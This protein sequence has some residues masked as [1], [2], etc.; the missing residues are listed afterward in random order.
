MYIL[1]EESE[2]GLVPILDYEI[3]CEGLEPMKVFSLSKLN[4]YIRLNGLIDKHHSIDLN[5]TV[6]NFGKNKY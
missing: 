4:E 1:F 2:H 6:G 3:E 5:Q